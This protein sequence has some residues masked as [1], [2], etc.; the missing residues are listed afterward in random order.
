[1]TR[2]PED[3]RGD[4]Q[5]GILR[6]LRRAPESN[7]SLAAKLGLSLNVV[8]LHLAALARDGLIRP[9]G[10]R[11]DTGGKPARL[12]SLTRDGEELFPKA[13]AAV[14]AT[15]AEVITGQEGA[16]RANELF[17]AA[18]ERIAASLGA[19]GDREFRVG[20]AADALRG[21]G[22]DVDVLKD[23]EGWVIKGYGCPLSRVTAH[24]PEV[25][26]LARSLVEEIVG[27]RVS[28]CCDRKESPKCQF[29]VG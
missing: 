3:L 16:A 27:S 24:H 23:G 4:S 26:E 9:A 25:C 12:Y 15:L 22:G 2:F 18:G 6:L 13:Y 17:R 7:G 10:M 11:T 5:S 28:E 8:R 14:L 1:M 19:T 29:R 20:A 21:L